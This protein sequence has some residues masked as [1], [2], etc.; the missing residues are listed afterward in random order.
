MSLGSLSRERWKVLEPLL[1]S[2]LE[3]EPSKRSAFL[4]SAC[5]GDAALRAELCA[6][7]TACARGSEMLETPAAITYAPLLAES[8]PVVPQVLGGRDRKSVV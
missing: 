6:L 2:A 8:T 7:L 4:D 1:D 5:R 3:L